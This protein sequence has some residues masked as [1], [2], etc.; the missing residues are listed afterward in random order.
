MRAP[1]TAKELA[2]I[3]LKKPDALV[4]FAMDG[5]FSTITKVESDK[6]V[7]ADSM[8]RNWDSLLDCFILSNIE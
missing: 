6:I 8:E 5:Y 3:L 2:E 4:Y 1:M 7:D